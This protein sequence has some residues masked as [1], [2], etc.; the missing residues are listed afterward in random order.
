VNHPIGS[1]VDA[2]RINLRD[3]VSSRAESSRKMTLNAGLHFVLPLPDAPSRQGASCI[4]TRSRYIT[5]A[6]SILF[7]NKHA[8]L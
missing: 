6:Y 5:H 1:P 4:S 7:L 2:K 8:T 3:E